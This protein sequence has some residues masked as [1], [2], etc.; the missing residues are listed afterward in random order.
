M[1]W[2]KK[3]EW[4]VEK[5]TKI[6]KFGWNSLLWMNVMI[7][8]HETDWTND[9]GNRCLSYDQHFKFHSLSCFG[10]FIVFVL[11]EGVFKDSWQS[12]RGWD[13]YREQSSLDTLNQ[14][15]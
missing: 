9:R 13:K 15:T 10:E 7:Y 4:W 11:D 1:Q 12:F 8:Y 5:W 6:S 14:T 3:R 2:A